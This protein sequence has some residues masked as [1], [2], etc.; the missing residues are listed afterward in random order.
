MEPRKD[1]WWHEEMAKGLRRLPAEW[2][3]AEDPLFILYTS[4]ST[5]KPKGVMAHHGGYLVF[6]RLYPQ[7]GFRLS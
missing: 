5:G 7:D 1:L 2:M 3:D 4:G 6:R